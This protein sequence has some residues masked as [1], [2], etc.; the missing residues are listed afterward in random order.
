MIPRQV[1]TER[2]LPPPYTL[3][4]ESP[5]RQSS[6]QGLR[7]LLRGHTSDDGTHDLFSEENVSHRSGVTESAT[8]TGE[9]EMREVALEHWTPFSVASSR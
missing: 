8:A 6:R 4:D 1:A 2:A 7:S 3:R 5:D 9:I